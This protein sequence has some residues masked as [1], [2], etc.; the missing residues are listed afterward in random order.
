MKKIILIICTFIFVSLNAYPQSRQDIVD[1]GFTWFEA[2]PASELTG[3]NNAPVST[4]WAL[5]S[6]LRLIG[7]YP[8]RSG[9]KLVISKDGKIVA[10]TRCE[11]MI[12]HRTGNDIDESFIRTAECWQGKSATKE[13]GNFDVQIFAI[14]GETTQEKLVRTYKINVYAVNRVPS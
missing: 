4:G 12:Y 14:N 3:N 1:D 2:F 13:I 5:K 11:A 10:A 6:W 8:N 9:F 7:N